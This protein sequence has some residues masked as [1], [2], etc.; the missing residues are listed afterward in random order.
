MAKLIAHNPQ[1][2][3]LK[4]SG[5]I[6]EPTGTIE[7]TENGEFNVKPFAVA[8]VQVPQP[9]GSITITEN[10]EHDVAD[11]EIANVDVPPAI[12]VDED[13]LTPIEFGCDVNGFYFASATG[14]GNTFSFGRDSTGVYAK[15]EVANE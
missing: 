3:K 7:I 9:S 10:G 15:Q 13:S 11:Y 5:Y 6:G 12:P 8:D 14:E 4:S 1:K 2:A